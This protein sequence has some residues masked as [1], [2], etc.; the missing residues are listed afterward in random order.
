MPLPDAASA[1]SEL[2][3]SDNLDVTLWSKGVLESTPYGYF[4]KMMTSTA[5]ASGART[6]ASHIKFDH[7]AI[8]TG[9]EVVARELPRGKRVDFARHGVNVQR[10]SIELS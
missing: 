5:S 9:P 6:Q 10:T 2:G 1:V 4:H 3:R 7:D 8:E